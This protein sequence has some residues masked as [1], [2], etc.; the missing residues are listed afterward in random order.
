MGGDEDFGVRC[1][2][3]HD[4]RVGQRG[5]PGSVLVAPHEFSNVW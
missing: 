1:V 5:I 2:V 4:Y 3:G